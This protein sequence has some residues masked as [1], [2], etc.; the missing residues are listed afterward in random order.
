MENFVITMK[1]SIWTDRKLLGELGNYVNT[2]EKT[3]TENDKYT[4]TYTYQEDQL[5]TPSHIWVDSKKQ[6]KW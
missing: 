2:T 1:K 3:N 5:Y 6:Q 4:G